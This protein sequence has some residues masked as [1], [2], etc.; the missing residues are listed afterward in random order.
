MSSPVEN[1]FHNALSEFKA[2]LTLREQKDFEFTSLE[3]VQRTIL[4]IQEVQET[5]KT[6]MHM[7]RIQSF[8]EA[9]EEFGSVIEVF[10]NAS[11]FVAFIWGP[12]KFMLQVR[13][14]F[15][16][17]QLPSQDSSCVH[18]FPFCT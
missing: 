17:I 7:S 6:M 2:R 3:D 5:R 4:Q 12:M 9:M 10:L 11:Q 18:I 13:S 14:L 16:L 1:V 15:T 8:L